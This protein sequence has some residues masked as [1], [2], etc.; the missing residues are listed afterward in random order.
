MRLSWFQE[1]NKK[2]FFFPPKYHSLLIV[3]VYNMCLNTSKYDDN[4]RK[5]GE[6]LEFKVQRFF[7][8]CLN[9]LFNNDFLCSSTFVR[10]DEHDFFHLRATKI[11]CTR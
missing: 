2:N 9:S 10:V 4:T 5:F 3:V 7:L 6:Y 1:E 8:G 11:T